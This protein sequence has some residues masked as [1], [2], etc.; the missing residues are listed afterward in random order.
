MNTRTE[1]IVETVAK[2]FDFTVD[3]FR[4]YGP[5]NLPTKCFG[6]FRSDTGEFIGSG[7]NAVTSR[8]EPHT[9]DDVIAL[10][11][12]ASTVF[13]GELDLRCYWNDGHY[14]NIIPSKSH[15]KILHDNESVF[16]RLIIRAGYDQK[17]FSGSLGS[18]RDICKN[19]AM[20]RC[21]SSYNVSIRHTSG[22]RKRMAE[23]I[24]Q[25]AEL[26]SAWDALGSRI[27]QMRNRE[28]FIADFLNNVYPLT[29]NPSQRE[30]T[31]H[32]NRTEE[33]VRRIL[34]ERAMVG[35]SVSDKVNAWQAYNGVQG[36]VQWDATRKRGTDNWGRILLASND[37]AVVRAEGLA[38]AS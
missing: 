25:F 24:S 13:D 28:V 9:T 20:M 12:A 33:I 38:L 1:S 36:Y 31:I 26:A 18:Y 17:P 32:K 2:E 23:L 29:A 4:L 14:V 22:L 11:E 34:R 10:T 21:V 30:I 16:P 8:Y 35:Q 5:E 15:R 6:L 27:D 19:L 3:K 7:N 37:K